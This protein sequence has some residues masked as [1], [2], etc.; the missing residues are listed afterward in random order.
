[1]PGMAE[2]AGRITGGTECYGRRYDC[3][4]PLTSLG[5]M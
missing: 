2:H 1:M 3:D 5:E 4:N